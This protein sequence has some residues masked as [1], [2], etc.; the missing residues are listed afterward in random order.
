MLFPLE[1]Y[2]RTRT[3]S[4]DIGTLSQNHTVKVYSGTVADPWAYTST[5]VNTPS[6]VNENRSEEMSDVETPNFNRLKRDGKIVNSPMEL[7]FTSYKRGSLYYNQRCVN[8]NGSSPNY[9]FTGR[10]D[11]GYGIISPYSWTLPSEPALP[12]LNSWINSV[13]TDMWSKVSVKQNDTIASVGEMRETISSLVSIFRRVIEI[14]RD[15]RR[16]RL[17]SVYRKTISPKAL[18]EYYMFYR[19]ALRPLV[20]EAQSYVN[21]LVNK[22]ILQRQTYRSYR[23]YSVP[24]SFLNDVTLNTTTGLYGWT[25]KG[26]TIATR[27]VEIRGGVLC[28]LDITNNLG[29][30]GITEPLEGI[31][32]LI[33]FSFI[34]DWFWNIGKFIASWTPNFGIEKLASW[35]VVTD[36]TTLQSIAA[37]GTNNVSYNYWNDLVVSGECSKTIVRKWRTPDPSRPIL[38]T[39]QVNLG[40]LKSLDIGII[41]KQLIA[42]KF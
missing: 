29:R 24:T 8:R 20:F 34:I 11:Q 15:L 23:E 35:V 7:T 37:S 26:Q 32:E 6:Y 42:S 36:T 19:Y 33:P 12:N 41:L 9:Y 4:Q 30:W 13:V 28:T 3:R 21:V 10:T 38:P 18:A 5:L 27:N 22:T 2:T 40:W 1:C 16:L 31:W 39:W 25:V 14:Y 17:L